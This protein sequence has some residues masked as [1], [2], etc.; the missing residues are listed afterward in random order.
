MGRGALAT[1][2]CNVT[3]ACHKW[4][5]EM[6]APHE[7]AGHGIDTGT[8]GCQLNTLALSILQSAA[9]VLLK[10]SETYE[11]LGLQG[12]LTDLGGWEM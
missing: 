12:M 4:N 7:V 11:R 5:S 1:P 10:H 8:E 3:E 2:K 6:T 9:S